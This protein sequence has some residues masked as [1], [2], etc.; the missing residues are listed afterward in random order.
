MI[1]NNKKTDKYILFAQER[2]HI[3][4]QDTDFFIRESYNTLR[5]NVTF[6]LTG[7]GCKIISVTSTNPGEGKSITSLNLAIAYAEIGKKVL[8]ID[9]DLRKPKVHRLLDIKS[10][11]GISNILINECEPSDAVR[12]IDKYGIDVIASGDIPPNS[13]QLLE[14]EQFGKILDVFRDGYDYIIID[15]PP[16]NVVIDACIL[17]KYTSGIVYVIKMGY[18]KK[19][20]VVNAVKQIEFSQGRIVG[21]VMNDVSDKGILNLPYAG[22]YRKKGYSGYNY[23]YRA[24]KSDDENNNGH[25]HKDKKSFFG[26]FMHKIKKRVLHQKKRKNGEKCRKTGKKKKILITLLAFFAVIAIA[27]LTALLYNKDNIEAFSYASKYTP[28]EIQLKNSELDA[29]IRSISEKLD[30]VYIQPL[31]DEERGMLNN[32]E[33][34]YDDAMTIITVT[35]GEYSGRN[36]SKTN[37]LVAD[38][39][40]LKAEF[41]NSIDNLIAQGQE[42]RH[43]VPKEERTLSVK[44]DM[45]K[46]YAKLGSELEEQ[47]DVRVENLLNELEK[48]L[49]ATGQD[50]SVT[51]EIKKLYNEE[52]KLKKAALIDA[53]YPVG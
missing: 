41:L 3:L 40:L 28:E 46:K 2:E 38:F 20:T 18:A 53:Y 36:V 39:Y 24:H 35:Y 31:T 8:L 14:S 25:E 47:C 23:E 29:E 45:A 27:V 17:A 13:T 34:S 44:L 10:S 5:S 48:E 16:V 52:K 51:E 15:T 37:E 4:S 12:K 1:F 21:F 26:N 7:K 11:P 32:G 33:L 6:S 42:E 22:K 19:D 9:C 43:S 49:E 30:D 50:T